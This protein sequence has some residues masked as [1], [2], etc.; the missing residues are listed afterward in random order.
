[1]Y[2]KLG[3]EIVKINQEDYI[4]VYHFSIKTPHLNK[5]LRPKM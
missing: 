4:M 2:L 1:M 5:F 3:F